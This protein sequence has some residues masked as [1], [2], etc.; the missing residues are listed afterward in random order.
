MSLNMVVMPILFV[1]NL[2]YVWYVLRLYILQL[3]I[4]F[5]VYVLKI[6]ENWLRVD[7]VIAI[8]WPAL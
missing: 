3:Q 1:R 4:F 6:I 8:I 5:S 2:S 7:N